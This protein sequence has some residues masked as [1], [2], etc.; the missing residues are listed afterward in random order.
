MLTPRS[1]PI[2]SLI[3]PFA[4]LALPA[5]T[6]CT[7]AQSARERYV[8]A[9]TLEVGGHSQAA[10]DELIALAH[11]APN[12]RAGRRA[13]T[14]LTSGSL[15][16][17]VAV[18]ATLASVG[19]PGFEGLSMQGVRA[20]ARIALRDLAEIQ[21]SFAAANGRFCTTFEECGWQAPR[22]STYLYYLSPTEVTGGTGAED[23]SFLRMQ[24]ESTLGGMNLQ[25][26][27]TRTA[28][29]LMAV[30]DPDDDGDL[31]VWSMDEDDNLVHLIKDD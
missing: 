18:L 16:T 31:D 2:A 29:V 22:R 14:I 27:V 28:F 3:T 9:M 21:H 19:F 12:T 11:D 7:T 6:A 17:D 5:L 15:V 25:P 30:G 26:S 4:F 8:H 10:Y 13:R 20:E 23:A 24:A 1:L